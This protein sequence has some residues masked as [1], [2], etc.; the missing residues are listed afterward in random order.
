MSQKV[1]WA[2]NAQLAKHAGVSTM[3]VWRWKQMP[4]FPPPAVVNGIEYRDLDA[5]DS[6]MSAF[7]VRRD[8][9]PTRGQ[10]AAM[11][12]K[13]GAQQMPGAQSPEV[14]AEAVPGASNSRKK[15]GFRTGRLSPP[16]RGT[17]RQSA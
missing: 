13:G 17:P 5:F 7:M 10:R 15:P 8:A 9:E 4:A 12:L 3:T 1:R 11:N 16:R 6:W 2:P 14:A